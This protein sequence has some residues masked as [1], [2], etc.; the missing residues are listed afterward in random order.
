VSRR[1][2]GSRRSEGE[3][4]RRA[5]SPAGGASGAG[6][7][8]AD[9]VSAPRA[10]GE[11]RAET[12]RSLLAPAA[13]LLL[14]TLLAYA[15]ALRAGYIW[16]DDFH[17]TENAALT[18]VSGI[19]T[20]WTS[21][22]SIPQY[23]PLV[24][25]TFWLEYRLWG[26]APF[27]YHLVNVLL[28]ALAAILLWRT[29]ARLSVPGS[30]L[31][32]AVFALL[33]VH[34]ESVAWI[35]ERKN[36][37]S[38]VLYLAALLCFLRFHGL[39]GGGADRGGSGIA[40]AGPRDARFYAAGC[41]LFLLALLSKTVVF[42]LPAAVLLIVWWKT[43][44]LS[45]R[46]VAPQIPLV[47]VGAAFGLLTSWLEKHHVGA[48][49]AEW[50]M[51]PVERVLVA[52]RA[53]WFYAG[54]LLWPS[55]LVFVYPRWNVS[56]SS[57]VQFL[58][59]LGFLALVLALLVLSRR[60]GRGPAAA[61]LFFAGTLF[62]ALGF[63]DIYPMRYA[64]V[65]DHFQYLAS[66]GIIA[67]VCGLVATAFA[68]ASGTGRVPAIAGP[69][70]GAALLAV[71]GTLVWR[72]CLVY[73]DAETLWKDTI[74]KNPRAWMAHDNLGLLLVGRGELDRAIAHYRAA[75]AI[76]PDEPT[77]RWNLGIAF[78]KKRADTE[79]IAEFSRALEIQPDLISVRYSLGT[80]Q[81]RS[82]DD[83]G[84]AR[85]FQDIIRR[86]PRH[87]EAHSNLALALSHL[88]REDE[89]VQHYR[90]ALAINPRLSPA[91]FNM[92]SLLESRGRL[93]E[94][95]WAYAVC[96]GVDPRDQ[97]ARVRLAQVRARL[98][99]TRPA[100]TNAET[101]ATPQAP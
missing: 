95:A 50:T 63:I 42:S 87:A 74:A 93:E 73:R 30:W 69:V 4:S 6:P 24:H 11:G 44:R 90:A 18:T 23:Y 37:L 67:L 46:D 53:L 80:S 26:L 15:P 96:L 33:P 86:A 68:R 7:R 71:L 97:E 91:A 77:V 79:A 47:V 84:A 55:P 75:L 2:R 38:G 34:V 40:G 32:G 61:V 94:A 12:V 72:Q 56:G 58:Y 64:Y 100:A 29:F 51:T 14:L 48:H 41:A 8:P 39:G 78:A 35:T 62:P 9:T 3:G 52:G 101:P 36:V 76:H 66:A 19:W 1:G 89:A 70:L 10:P 17:V 31:A 57:P 49:G 99:R 65:A 92:G 20:I 83:A 88:D 27:G 45:W 5:G 81:L 16:D 54:K 85:T 82:G 13:L 98:Q 43:G 60:L 25:S 22:T 28:H 21:P 59:P